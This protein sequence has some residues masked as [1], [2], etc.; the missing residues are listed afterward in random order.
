MDLS[1]ASSRLSRPR[2]LRRLLPYPANS[3]RCNAFSLSA[4]RGRPSPNQERWGLRLVQLGVVL[5]YV[6][7][8]TNKLAWED[9]WWTGDV[10]YLLTASSNWGRFPWP[11]FFEMGWATR[12]ATWGS[13]AVEM[14]FPVL[15]WIPRTRLWSIGLLA[16]LHVVIACSIK[17]ATFFNLEMLVALCAF[18]R[19]RDL[20]RIGLLRVLND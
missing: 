1:L 12:A 14:S 20:A 2:A 4:R 16:V 11:E 7:T 13:L 3:R 5:L 10:L 9:L 17:G 6:F 19:E 18:L 15:V 8:Q